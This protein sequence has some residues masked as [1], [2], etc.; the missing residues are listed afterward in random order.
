MTITADPITGPIVGPAVRVVPG[1]SVNPAPVLE[2]IGATM[3]RRAEVYHSY[4]AHL[5]DGPPGCPF[6]M[7][8]SPASERPVDRQGSMLVVIN[9]W[10][11]AVW[12]SA[13]VEDHRMIVPARHLL[14]F[15]E[16]TEQEAADFWVLCRRYEADGYSMYTRSQGNKGRSVGHL[17]THLI[18]TGDFYRA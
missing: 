7:S 14:S 9:A 18:K 2:L 8:H 5:S 3:G 1:E 4:K 15:E 17:H 12:D 11:Y 10:P 6:C 13:L 16:F